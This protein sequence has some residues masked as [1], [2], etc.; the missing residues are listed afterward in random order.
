MQT[1]KV[2]ILCRLMLTSRYS[3]QRTNRMA[4]CC[5]WL[6]NYCKRVVRL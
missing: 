6:I 5:W 2:F 4:G 3:F 1:A